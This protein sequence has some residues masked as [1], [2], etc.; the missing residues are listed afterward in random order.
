MLWCIHQWIAGSGKGI[1]K[2][3]RGG[4]QDGSNLE[5][6][7]QWNSTFFAFSLIIEGTTEKVFHFIKP[8]ESI[9]NRSF[10]FI[11]QKMYFWQLQRV[12]GKKKLYYL[13]L[14][15]PW[16]NILLTSSELPP[17]C[18]CKYYTKMRC[19]IGQSGR[20]VG[21]TGVSA[22]YHCRVAKWV[23]ILL[24]TWILDNLWVLSLSRQCFHSSD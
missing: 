11:D 23:N 24:Y 17:I 22:T 4:S 5:L 20:G 15:L 2:Y 8:L 19:S 3:K 7:D 21:R 14:F 18:L 16:K 9:Y 1:I 6:Y 12:C 10:G 13:K